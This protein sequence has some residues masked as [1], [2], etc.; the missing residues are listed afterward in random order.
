[1]AYTVAQEAVNGHRN[2]EMYGITAGR[3]VHC[4]HAEAPLSYI[5]HVS[6][7]HTVQSTSV[8]PFSMKPS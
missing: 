3:C 1:M 6:S 8:A 2:H 7:S 5:S 4:G